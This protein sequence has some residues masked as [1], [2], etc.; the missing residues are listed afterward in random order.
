MYNLFEEPYNQM[1][2]SYLFPLGLNLK[3]IRRE[4]RQP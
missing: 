2:A 1:T 3:K 4:K